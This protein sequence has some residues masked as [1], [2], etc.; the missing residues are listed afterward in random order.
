MLKSK[1]L[2]RLIAQF[3]LVEVV[4]TVATIVGL[5][6]TIFSGKK[7]VGPKKRERAIKALTKTFQADGVDLSPG[8]LMFLGYLVDIIGKHA[9]NLDSIQEIT[10]VWDLV[11]DAV[12]VTDGLVAGNLAQREVVVD[13]ING[14]VDIPGID[15][16]LEES[17]IRMLVNTALE[18]RAEETAAAERAEQWGEKG[19]VAT[20]GRASGKSASLRDAKRRALGGTGND[21]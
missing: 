6:E 4:S 17:L 20:A 10:R 16:G 18:L 15:E 11:S 5:L 8:A 2:T 12:L 21:L 7:G 13:L 9:G 1:N 14:T 3:D 19:L